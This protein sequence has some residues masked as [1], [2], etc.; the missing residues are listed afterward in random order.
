M[1]ELLPPR[2]STMRNLTKLAIS[3]VAFN[4]GTSSRLTYWSYSIE[5]I[6]SSTESRTLRSYSK[7]MSVLS[8]SSWHGCNKKNGCFFITLSS[9]NGLSILTACFSSIASRRFLNWAVSL[10]NAYLSFITLALLS[11]W[12]KFERIILVLSSISSFVIPTCDWGIKTQSS[13]SLGVYS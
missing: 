3:C 6:S 9:L 5:V 7:T 1:K 13:S 4:S 10:E 12:K 11:K 2:L 8:F